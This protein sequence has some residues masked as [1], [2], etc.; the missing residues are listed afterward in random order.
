MRQANCCVWFQTAPRSALTASHFAQNAAV[1]FTETCGEV[2][3]RAADVW[4]TAAE[5]QEDAVEAIRLDAIDM[6]EKLSATHV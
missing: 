1:D 4:A 5:D 6:T 2:T 3:I